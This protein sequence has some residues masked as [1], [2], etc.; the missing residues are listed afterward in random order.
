M[1]L[2]LAVVCAGLGVG[3]LSVG[4]GWSGVASG[5]WTS[6]GT[7]RDDGDYGTSTLIFTGKIS[8]SANANDL[9]TGHSSGASLLKVSVCTAASIQRRR[10]SGGHRLLETAKTH[11]TGSS[12]KHVS[13]NELCR[14]AVEDLELVGRNDGDIIA[15]GKRVFHLRIAVQPTHETDGIAT[16][17]DSITTCTF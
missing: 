8:G 2:I 11:F 1:T 3:N 4:D 13:V 9:Q 6:A 15:S 12:R 10:E 7:C 14:S 17:S 16:A 5:I